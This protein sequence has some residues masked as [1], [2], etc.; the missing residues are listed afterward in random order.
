MYWTTYQYPS[1]A[2][3]P[4]AEQKAIIRAAL[5]EYGQGY[6]RRFLIVTM[7]FLFAMIFVIR[8]YYPGYPISDWRFWVL[9]FSFGALIRVYLLWETNG[10]IHEA[11]KKYLA[12]R[13]APPPA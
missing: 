8:R 10:P 13:A 11:V 6:A 3:R 5:K 9:P 7:A 1:L 12:S 2:G 4:R